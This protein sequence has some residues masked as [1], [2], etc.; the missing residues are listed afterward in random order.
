M[1]VS[2]PQFNILKLYK[3]NY[4][5]VPIQLGDSPSFVPPWRPCDC[6]PGHYAP[7]APDLT[8]VSD[9][10]MSVKYPQPS[11]TPIVTKSLSGGTISVV[12]PAT[13]GLIHVTFLPADFSSVPFPC[14]LQTDI[15]VIY[16][17]SQQYTVDG[18]AIDFRL[19]VSNP[20]TS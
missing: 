4:M 9:I 15:M 6:G 1:R 16:P 11:V 7:D 18:L 3:N 13:D 5:V 2:L 10:V 20:I 19:P 17:N 14:Y 12:T 8:T